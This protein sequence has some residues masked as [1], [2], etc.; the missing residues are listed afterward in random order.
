[1]LNKIYEE[2][3]MDDYIY[4]H[5]Y[6]R[7]KFYEYPET[8]DVT[9]P[10]IIIDPLEPPTPADYADGIWLTDDYLYQIDVWTRNRQVRDELAKRI[11][12]VMWNIGF[13]QFGGGVDEYD[14]GIYRDA[15]RYRGKQYI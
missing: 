7:I 9:Q 6:G 14:S 1:M 15:R 12:K 5:A 4:E 10:H 2:M 11:Q 3:I 8:G 13:G